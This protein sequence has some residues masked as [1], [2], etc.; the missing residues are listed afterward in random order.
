MTDDATARAIAWL[1]T[2][3]SHGV[4]RTTTT[5]DEAGADWL[6]WEVARLGAAPRSSY[7]RWIAST[8]SSPIWSAAARAFLLGWTAP[9]GIECAR[10]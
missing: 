4:H 8:R 10:L 5:G 1:S 9:Y 6:T 3:D 2:W 7:T